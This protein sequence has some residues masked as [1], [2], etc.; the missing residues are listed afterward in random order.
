MTEQG[1]I[2]AIR[3]GDRKAFDA[4]CRERY[5]SLIS[6]AR[7]FVKDDWAED[8]VQDVLFGVWERRSRLRDDGTLSGYL[9]R[10]VYNRCVNYLKRRHTARSYYDERILEI[11]TG[12]YAPE[13]NP[14]LLGLFRQDLR[15]TIESA[16]STLSPRVREVFCMSYL[17]DMSNKEIAERLG[18]STSTVE[19]HMYTALKQLRSILAGV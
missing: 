17:E 19:N 3:S 14:V 15:E 9:L 1:Y 18:L 2:Y 10:S 13:S 11:M 12:Y 7:L 16:I 8:V 5:S 6:Y 4:F